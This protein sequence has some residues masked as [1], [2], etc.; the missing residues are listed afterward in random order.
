MTPVPSVSAR[1]RIALRTGAAR[2]GAIAASSASDQTS[3]P[4]YWPPAPVARPGRRA[5]THLHRLRRRREPV[6]GSA[7]PWVA[8]TGTGPD[9]GAY[10]LVFT[11]LGPSDRWFVRTAMYPG[12][13][14][15]FAFE[16][17]AV[18]PAGDNRHARHTVT[19]ADGVLDGDA[20]A[21]PAATVEPAGRA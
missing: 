9:G 19:V 15:A 4:T 6:N 12:V 5:T 3:A 21:A 14:V 16:T 20:V 17:P 13:C 10:T 7:E 11:G 2:P 18:V 8:L 1:A